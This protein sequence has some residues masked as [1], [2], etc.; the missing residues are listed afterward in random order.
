[1]TITN[2]LDTRTLS[3][4]ETAPLKVIVRN[5]NTAAH[6]NTGIRIP[7][8]CWKNGKVVAGKDK[9]LMEATPAILNAR[10]KAF[11]A[12]L[13]MII[14]EEIGK[15]THLTAA[16]IKSIIV[17]RLAR[18]EVP[19]RKPML[20]LDDF[21]EDV[22]RKVAAE[23]RSV[24]SVR[25]E[26]KDLP[27][28]KSMLYMEAFDHFIAEDKKE[29]SRKVERM[30]KGF[31]LRNLPE[32]RNL[33]L[34]DFTEDVAKKIAAEL[35]KRLSPNTAWNYAVT[36]KAVITWAK[37]K[38]LAP[39]YLDPFAGIKLHKVATKSRA[40]TIE[41]AREIWFAEPSPSTKPL[42]RKLF[43]AGRD[44]FRLIMGLAGINYKDLV[45]LTWEELRGGR[46]VTERKKTGVLINI[47]IE[48]EVQEIIDRYSSGKGRPLD[49][50]LQ[51]TQHGRGG[52]GGG[53]SHK[54]NLTLNWRMKK[55]DNR[56][57]SY[58]VRHT[59]ASLAAELDI[60]DR[61]ITMGLAHAY[62]NPMDNVYI[63]NRVRKLDA[64]NRKILDW[65]IKG[66]DGSVSG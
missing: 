38:H 61:V 50:L 39:P 22:A 6:I 1:M 35:R 13:V 40:L 12:Q 57:S 2:F 63:T 37:R 3:K 60:P 58:W 26:T 66:D 30:Q 51:T 7:P 27:E 43:Y 56:L 31:L 29:S 47:K 33:T 45:E 5:R 49:L 36:Y 52:K 34:D 41:E 48:P 55:I 42:G 15:K 28:R 21:T 25:L 59:W 9:H 65:I 32:L 24:M 10:I 54:T 53:P 64:A 18:E 16:E 4:D 14:E 17:A 20:S 23:L 8:G 11:E 19:E 44:T 62:G 46:L